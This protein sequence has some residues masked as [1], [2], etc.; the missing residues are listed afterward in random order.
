[1]DK[2]SHGNGNGHK[3]GNGN[4]N[5]PHERHEAKRVKRNAADRRRVPPLEARLAD[6]H[7]F[8]QAMVDGEFHIRMPVRR[9]GS[10]I[11]EIAI[12]VNELNSRHEE[13]TDEIVRIERVVG[14]EG[15]MDD[16]AHLKEANGGWRT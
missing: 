13:M 16:R 12:I 11:D 4:G 3:N 5:P 7:K 6:V 1:M 14:R 15:R 8:L 2:T 10:L 9:D